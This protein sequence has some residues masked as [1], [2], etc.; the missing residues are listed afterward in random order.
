MDKETKG[1]ESSLPESECTQ[2]QGDA[3][4]NTSTV[5]E[6]KPKEKKRLKLF[7]V[8]VVYIYLF[9]IWVAH[10]GWLV[11]NLVKLVNHGYIDD[12]FHFL[13]FISPYALIAFAFHIALRDPDDLV[14]FGKR[15]FKVQTTKTKIW[16]NILSFLLIC[17]F[18]FLGELAVGNLWEIF[19]NVRLWDYHS[20]PLNVTRYTSIV[21]TFGFGAGAYLI[22]RFIYKPMMKLIRTKVNF[23]VAKIITLTLGIAIIIDTS[24]LMFTLAFYND[25]PHYWHIQVFIPGE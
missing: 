23:K 24:V 20:W 16:S 25:V 17:L 4:A 11:E 8:E 2:V 14:L 5:T 19:F 22:F 18:V 7:G 13:P 21:S 12:K 3:S 1:A 9:G 10:V 6:E 15:I